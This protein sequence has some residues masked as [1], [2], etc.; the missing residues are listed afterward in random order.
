[1]PQY[2]PQNEVV[3]YTVRICYGERDR[4]KCVSK[5]DLEVMG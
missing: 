1:M 4:I 3:M 2:R 5:R